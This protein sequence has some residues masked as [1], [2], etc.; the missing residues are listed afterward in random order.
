MNY[1]LRSSAQPK[2]RGLKSTVLFCLVLLE[3][4]LWAQAHAEGL[5]SRLNFQR[6]LEN[7]DIA[8]GE[9][10]AIFQDSE[11]FMWFGSANALIRYDGYTFKEI[12]L[13]SDDK[14]APSKESVKFVS[15]I[16][17]DKHHNIWVGTRT[18][19]YKYTPRLGTITALP[20]SPGHEIKISKTRV[21]RFAQL[22]SGELLAASTQGVLVLNPE[23]LEYTAIQPNKEENKGL[24]S[25]RVNTVLIDVQGDIWLGGEFGLEKLDWEAKRSTLYKPYPADPKAVLPNTVTDLI[26]D[27]RGKFW[28]ATS[29]GLVHFDPATGN[30]KRYVHDPKN[31]FSLGGNDTWRVLLDSSGLLWVASDKGGISIFDRRTGRFTNHKFEA[32][33]STSLSSNMPRTLYEDNNS[34]I[35]IGNY[36]DGINYFDRSSAGITSYSRDPSDIN[37]LSHNSVLSIQEDAAGNLWLGTDGGGLNFFDRE[38]DTFTHFKH[39]PNDETSISSNAVLSVL[40]DSKGLVWAGTWGGGV[41]M[42]DPQTGAFARVPFD[43]GR[44]SDQ[45]VSHSSRL[46]SAHVWSIKEDADSNLWISTHTGGLSKYDRATK[47]YTH[48]T[49]NDADPTSVNEPLVWSTFED[50]EG[51]FWVGTSSGLDLMDRESDTFTHFYSDPNDPH[52]LSDQSILSMYEDSK[53]RL[54]FGTDNGLN[55]YNPEKQN[56]TAIQKEHGLNDATIR[57]ILEDKAGNLWLSTNNGVSRFNPETKD[58]KNYN[59]DSGR[60]VG[61]FNTES[62]IVTSKGE[63][64]FGGI[65][66]LRFFN[67]NKLD[68]NKVAPPIAFTDFKIY[69][70]SVS[71]G[72]PDNLLHA[73]IN[74]TQEIR[75]DHTKSMFVLDF[76]ALN[77][78][79]SGKNQYAYKLEGFDDDW[80]NVGTQRSAKYTNLNAGTYV[81]RVKGTNNDG[82]WSEEGKDITIVQLPPPWKTWWAYTIYALIVLG[83]ILWFIRKQQVKRRAVEEQNRIL[84]AKVAERTA[85]LAQ[86]NHDIQAMLSNMPQGLFTVEVG[87]IIHPEYSQ[88]LEEIFATKNIAGKNVH[89]LLFSNAKIGAD[90]LESAKAAV[91]ATLGEDPM[92]FDFNA[93]LLVR[94]YEIKIGSQLKYLS[95]DWNPIIVN[96]TV[97]KLMVSV[98][99]VTQLKEMENQA[100]GQKRELEIISQ[101]LNVSAE[102]Y[103]A[104]EESTKHYIEANRSAIEAAESADDEVLALLFRNMHTVK[105]NCRTFGL[106][107]FSDTVHEVESTYSAMKAS[108]DIAWDANKLLDDLVRVEKGL[109]EYADVYRRVLGRG[110]KDSSGRHDGFWMNSSVMNTIQNYADTQQVDKLRYYLAK[111]QAAT[112]NDVLV[113]VI[114]SLSS[115]A[116]QLDKKTPIVSIEDNGIKIKKNGFELLTDTFAHILRNCVDHGIETPEERIALD[117]SERGQITINAMLIAA[118]LKIFVKDDGRGVDI[119]KLLAR[120][121]QLGV[122]SKDKT[123]SPDEIAELMFRSGVSTKEV[124]SDISG[125]GVGM[126]A[127]RNFMTQQGGNVEVIISDLIAPAEGFLPFELVLTLPADKYVLKTEVAKNAK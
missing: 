33:R 17:E 101:L 43:D 69:A 109:A 50:S 59:R 5:P 114:A 63:I 2:H 46:N 4:F 23:T 22:E 118:E 98:R 14:D 79:D 102:K 21:V 44:A 75:L 92:N 41:S 37:S 95:L 55:L 58:I 8:L 68:A 26:S 104:F 42:Y 20:D 11:G 73:S 27:Q 24:H 9:V 111:I 107:H 77:F 93:N 45:S 126:D 6:I 97:N 13:H 100:R 64:V 18:G 25:R 83:A 39:D 91:F 85:E 28:V 89:S 82:V 54:W 88:F 48:Y 19:V 120:G 36:P 35:W 86:K 38:L 62:G 29:D 74:H 1:L 84:E 67:P 12:A 121:R 70:D 78:R 115:I 76:S 66:G 53:G 124:V 123:Y 87:E 122:L 52:S 96:D 125:R 7:K 127:V 60:L 72:G 30:T 15:D 40:V 65:N 16:F 47:N 117:K 110:D 31:R 99:D 105:G 112:L 10:E 90:K 32:G 56:F 81:F 116:I 106:S 94:D 113:D 119:D 80:L 103:L 61:G 34:D 71:V 57:Q 49:P 51:R 108:A 3:S